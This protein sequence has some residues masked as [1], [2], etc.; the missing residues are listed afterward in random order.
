MRASQQAGIGRSPITSHVF[1]PLGGGQ[2]DEQTGN[3]GGPV[4]V[5][6][7]T[8]RWTLA[9]VSS[10][11]PNFF[12]RARRRALCN[13]TRNVPDAA[14]VW[15]TTIPFHSIP[16]LNYNYLIPFRS[17]PYLPYSFHSLYLFHSTYRAPL[18]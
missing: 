5:G 3:A 12:S 15:S 9:A 6:A 10:P 11:R 13:T 7:R 2:G 18:S 16:W 8:M 1:P 17:F 4:R 14:L